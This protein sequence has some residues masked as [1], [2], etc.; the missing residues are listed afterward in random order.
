MNRTLAALST[1]PGLSLTVPHT[2]P[3]A[4]ELESG[5]SGTCRSKTGLIRA[6]FF[7]LALHIRVR[8]STQGHQAKKNERIFLEHVLNERETWTQAKSL[9]V[10]DRGFYPK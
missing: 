8:S 5:A 6:I 9:P 4:Q 3:W 1:E 10:H 7:F 2:Y